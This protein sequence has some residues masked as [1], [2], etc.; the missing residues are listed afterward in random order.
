MAVFAQC[1]VLCSEFYVRVVILASPQ[2]PEE[3][4]MPASHLRYQT[5]QK[6]PPDFQKVVT[7]IHRRV[8]PST[9]AL[10][11]CDPSSYCYHFTD[12]KAETWRVEDM[13]SRLHSWPERRP[14]SPCGTRLPKLHQQ[15]SILLGLTRKIRVSCPSRGQGPVDRQGQATWA[16]LLVVCNSV[17]EGPHRSG[18]GWTKPGS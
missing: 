2:S 3:G 7:F 4:R 9:C 11:E 1:W 5:S 13:C 17:T 6:L 16:S 15:I 18:A 8:S 10:D 14:E 12:E